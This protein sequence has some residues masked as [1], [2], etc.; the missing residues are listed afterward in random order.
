MFSTNGAGLK[1]RK[2]DSLTAEVRSTGANIVTIQEMHCTQKGKIKMGQEF[3]VFE[4][5]CAKKGGGTMIAIHEDLN[6]KLV[7]EYN[8][9]FELLVVEINAEDM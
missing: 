7:E 6:P 5:I 9:D 1:N 4:A 8:D 3:V 2:V